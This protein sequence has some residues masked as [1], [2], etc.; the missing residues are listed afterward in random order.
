MVWDV[1]RG[2]R[3]EPNVYTLTS[4]I[5]ALA[6]QHDPESV[7]AGESVTNLEIESNYIDYTWNWLDYGDFRPYTSVF[8]A[9][10]VAV[11]IDNSPYVVKICFADNIYMNIM[12]QKPGGINASAP[13]DSYPD[14]SV[15]L[16]QC[17]K[18]RIQFLPYFIDGK[19]IGDC[20]LTRQSPGTHVSAYVLQDRVLA[21]LLNLH[22]ENRVS[23]KGELEPWLASNSKKYNVSVYDVNGILIEEYASDSRWLDKSRTMEPFELILYEFRPK[24]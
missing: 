15:A 7:F 3:K 9:P 6:R 13:I 2:T 12:P 14:L 11:N 8:P 16:K 24:I 4:K 17:A 21:I 5:R 20:I 23:L 1:Y 18:L 10:R 22:N 19:L